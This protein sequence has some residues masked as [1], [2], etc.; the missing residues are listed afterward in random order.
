MENF[1][2]L[3]IMHNEK[4]IAPF[5]SFTE[6]YLHKKEHLFIIL[7]GVS[8]EIIPIPHQSNIRIIDRKLLKILNIIAFSRAVK[9]YFIAADKVIVHGLFTGNV[10]NFL[11]LNTKFCQKTSWV[12]WG[13]DLYGYRN[14]NKNFRS[15]FNNLRK[16]LVVKKMAGL[17]TY[18]KG[19]YDL[20]KNWYGAKGQY[21]ECLMYPSNLYKEYPVQP[22]TDSTTNILIGNSADPSNNHLEILKILE[23]YKEGRIRIYAPL[24]Y[25]PQAYGR[26]V[27]KTG[28]QMFGEK[29]IALTDFMVF[30]KYLELLGKIDIAI[31]NHDRQQAMGNIIPLLGLGKKVYMRRNITPRRLFDE[32]GISV[33]DIDSFNLEQLGAEDVNLNPERVKAYF[34]ERNLAFQLTEIFENS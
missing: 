30:D 1:K 10:I 8:E 9:K 15:R 29:F 7:G 12:V 11:L 18:I 3:H 26:E 16:Q 13:E 31:F 22:K 4:F 19:D 21:Y 2:Y 34:C 6:D 24:S 25:G 28:Q 27:E 20:A 32:L 33:F 17:I 14:R 5:I 23:P